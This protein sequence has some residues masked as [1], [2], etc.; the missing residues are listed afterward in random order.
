MG[1]ILGPLA[2]TS[3]R[4]AIA[5]FRGQP[6]WIVLTRPVGVVLLLIVGWAAYDGIVRSLRV[7]R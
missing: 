3:F 5:I 1:I 7:Q 6:P 2:D 4:R